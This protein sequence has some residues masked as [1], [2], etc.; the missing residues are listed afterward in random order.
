LD[1]GFFLTLVTLFIISL[2]VIM[3]VEASPGDSAT[4]YLGQQATPE[5]L[6][7]LREEFGLNAPIHFD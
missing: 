3:G 5:S 4:A 1:A 6:A 2:I 7:A